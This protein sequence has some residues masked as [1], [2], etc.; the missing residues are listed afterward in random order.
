MKTIEL[1]EVP[2]LTPH[3]EV[4]A[5]PLFLTKNGHTVGAV[6][7]ANDEDVESMLLSSNPRF[8]EILHRSQERLESEG[9][10]S[11]ADVRRRLGL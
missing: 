1:S 11:S 6:V 2:A 3:L 4:G 10:L 7:P 5:E 9:G 8:Q